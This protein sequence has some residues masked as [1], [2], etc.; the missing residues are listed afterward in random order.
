[1][2]KIKAIFLKYQAYIHS[3]LLPLGIWGPGVISAIDSAA[4]GI[5]MDLVMI[6]YAWKDQ[7]HLFTVMFYCLTAAIGSAIGS[8]APY[9]IGRRGG[10]P[11]LLKRISH[12]KLER[13]RDRFE[14]QEFF[15]IMVP[16]MLPPPTPFKMLVFCSGV[17][18]M[19]VWQF[20]T[21]IVMGRVVRFGIVS[22]VTIRYGEVIAKQAL[23]TMA[24]HL[25]WVLALCV[26][27]LAL[28]FVHWMKNRKNRE[29]I[30]E[31]SG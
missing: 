7:D 27:A 25:P 20:A 11:F 1:M 8:L 29:L 2:K 22:F 4:F 10:E 28:Y 3:M 26:L 30:E 6:D 17:F 12:A 31:I 13:L 18:E 5:P 14:K 16:A 19:K 15:F 21:A 23:A 9:W 24:Q